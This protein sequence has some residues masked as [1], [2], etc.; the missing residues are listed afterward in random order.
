MKKRRLPNILT[1]FLSFSSPLSLSNSPIDIHN[2]RN[3]T[4]ITHK[5]HPIDLTNA[6]GYAKVHIDPQ[7]CF[8]LSKSD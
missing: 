2:S 3:I 7:L 1:K 5:K 8:S 4:E 6:I